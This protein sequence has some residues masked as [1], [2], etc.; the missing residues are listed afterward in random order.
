MRA[1]AEKTAPSLAQEVAGRPLPAGWRWVRLGEVTQIN[2][3]RPADLARTDNRSTSFI[4]MSAVDE[5]S[6]TAAPEV[7][8][9]AAVRKGYTYFAE[10]DVL[11]AKITPCM[12]NGK[13]AVAKSLLDGLGFGT[14]EFHVLRPGPAIASAWIHSFLRQPDVLQAAA[15]HFEGAVGQ[16]RVPK[17]F[18]A[19]L[20]IPL[21]PL[22]EQKRI[23]GVLSEQMAAVAKARAAAEAQLEA[24]MALPAAYLREVFESEEAKGWPRKRLGQVCQVS[25][26]QVDPKLPAYGKLPHVSGE[27]IE[28]GTCRL[29][30]LNSAAEDGMTSGK[31]LFDAGDVLYSKLRPYLRKVTVVDFCGLCSADM[32]PI[33]VTP[34]FLDAKFAAWMLL[35]DE[36]TTY[37]DEESRRARMPK[38]NRNQLFAWKAPLPPLA[39]QRR[40]ADRLTEQMAAAERLRQRLEEQLDLINKLPA[41]LL[42]QAFSGEL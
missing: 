7:R 5:Q 21:P 32:Y 25:A 37:A 40:I 23:A 9:F 33:K 10:G 18:L 8:P 11:F 17:Q 4:P 42:R 41:A 16:Q 38:L 27:N 6:G 34:T 2:P 26:R 20:E 22:R 39:E 1:Q 31:Y 29:L 13:H 14:T 28:P 36:F 12:Q 24:A 15:A 3:R 19:A 30:Y 35:S